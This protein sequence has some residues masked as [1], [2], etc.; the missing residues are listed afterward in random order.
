MTRSCERSRIGVMFATSLFL[1]S[2]CPLN[3]HNHTQ[4]EMAAGL[5]SHTKLAA[6]LELVLS[7]HISTLRKTKEDGMKRAKTT[8]TK[9]TSLGKP[10]DTCFWVEMPLFPSLSMT[11]A[12]LLKG[13]QQLD[14]E[15][16]QVW[17][18]R[19]GV[20]SLISSN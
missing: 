14:F 9:K 13:W 19:H 15:T 2:C 3:S 8:T 6:K 17:F 7:Y 18:F 20:A 5:H 12:R 10:A 4:L 1:S 16:S 11:A